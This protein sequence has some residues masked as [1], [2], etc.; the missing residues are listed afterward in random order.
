M[1]RTGSRMSNKRKTTKGREE[2]KENSMGTIEL[3]VEN[4]KI[5]NELMVEEYER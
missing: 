4:Q 2:H 5:K 3:S 1:G